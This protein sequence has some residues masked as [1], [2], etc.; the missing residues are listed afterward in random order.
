MENIIFIWVCQVCLSNWKNCVGWGLEGEGSGHMQAD[1]RPRVL[2]MVHVP[3]FVNLFLVIIEPSF[4]KN[5]IQRFGPVSPSMCP[6]PDNRIRPVLQEDNIM[7][8]S[9]H[10]HVPSY[11][12]TFILHFLVAFR[13]KRHRGKIS[14]FKI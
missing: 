7:F 6:C 11:G 8:T 14:R 12:T 13:A 5:T 4:R 3:R 9:I 10:L 2:E 1:D